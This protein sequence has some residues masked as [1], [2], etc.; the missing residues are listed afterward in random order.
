MGCVAEIENGTV[1]N[2]GGTWWFGRG[3]W[4]PGQ[5]V[6]ADVF[7]VTDAVSPGST[8]TVGYQAMLNG[9]SNIPDGSG[10]IVL[11]SYLVVY[12]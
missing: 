5:Q 4:C 6:D 8:V 3:G 10:N 12:E 1:P 7:D 9:S 11:S 2:Q